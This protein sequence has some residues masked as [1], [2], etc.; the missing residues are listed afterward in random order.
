MSEPTAYPLSWPHGFPRR[1]WGARK[2]GQFGKVAPDERHSWNTKKRLSVDDAVKRLRRQIEM[3]A[4]ARLT[5]ISTNM[6]LRRDGLPRSD[7]AAHADPGVA[8]YL[9]IKGKPHCLPCDRYNRVADNIA[10]VAAHIEATRAIA[11]HGVAD[12]ERAFMGFQALPSPDT[13]RPWH[14][15][16]GVEPDATPEQVKAKWKQ[17][18]RETHPDHGGSD[19]QMAEINAA[20]DEHKRAG[21][22]A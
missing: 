7:R 10:A 20:Y 4:G 19:A 6:E 3:L 9:T 17:R 16:L 21:K 2:D 14:Q 12:V 18:V 8:V 22:S 1:S 11:R 5:V 15:I 13:K